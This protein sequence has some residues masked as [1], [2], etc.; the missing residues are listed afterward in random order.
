MFISP[1]GDNSFQ[2]TI[3]KALYY[4]FFFFYFLLGNNL[5]QKD[6]K[7]KNITKPIYPLSTQIHLLIFAPFDL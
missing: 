5:K 7:N 4:S 2:M 6:F 1:F 3:T